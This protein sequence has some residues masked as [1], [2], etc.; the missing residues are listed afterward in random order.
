[1]T[2]TL[3]PRTRTPAATLI[4]WLSLIA[5]FGSGLLA[6]AH[7]GIELPL[8]SALGP[9]DGDAV[10]IA[11]AVFGVG[12]ALYT[13][14]ALGA[15]TGARW[16]WPLG[17]VVN[18]LGLA[19]GIGNYRGPVSAVGIGLAALSLIL[20]LSPGGRRAFRR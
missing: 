5:A 17:L 16:T 6:L 20:L 14:V 13:A 15:F 4:G 19:S 9:G 8:L 18:V 10:P 12:L 11:A 7:A 3:S 2:T 1:M